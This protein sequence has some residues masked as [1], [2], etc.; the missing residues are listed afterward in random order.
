MQ[1]EYD[2]LLDN[3]TWI[4]VNEPED[5]QVLPG[6]LL[7]LFKV[8]YGANGQV[9]KFKARYVAK[10]YAQ[11]EGVDF[12]DTYAP[13]CKPETFRIL[14][15]TATQK[16]LQ[17]GQMDVKSA[18]LHSNIEEEIYLEQPQ[19]FVKK[20]NSGQKLVCKLNK[21]IY[22][23]KQAAKNW[24]EALT[25]LLLKKGFKRSRNDYCLFV[26]KEDGTFSYVLVWVDDIVVAGATEEAVNEIKSILNETFKMDDRGVLNW[27]LGMQILRSNDK[28]TVDQKKYIETVLQEFNMNECKAV[29]TPGEV[30]LKLVKSNEEKKLV[31]PK[32]YR[33]LVGSLLFI[34]K[35][36]R[37]DILH[38]VNQ[39]SRFLDKPDESHWKA[40]KHVMR[41]LKGTIDL[42]LTFL[43]NSN[44]D[45][46][47]DSDADWSG[48]LNDRKSTTG[49][50]FKFEGSGGAISWEVKKQATVALS[51]VE[52]EYQ[53]MA[54]VVQEA[55]YLRALLEDFGFP[56]KK[57]IDIGE[58]NQS[59]IKMC[60]NP[61]MHKRSKHI[62]TKLHFI[63]ERVENKEVRIH[64]VPTEEMTADILTKSLPR[65]KV[66]RHRTILLG[67]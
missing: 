37:P 15:A 3:N 26:R 27:F 53:A 18:Y 14:L 56:M 63:R 51:T 38:V 57:A 40:A 44:L 25:S 46:I 36:T 61:V 64:Y 10:G 43:K 23:L 62:D 30:N 32:L 6:N 4:L 55:I 7:P 47:G 45:I 1:A 65:V 33:S 31:D 42:R 50:Y 24:Y 13:T 41:Y 66:E 29:A 11:I 59:C 22:G 16:D 28:I 39:L 21:S 12:F 48:D 5:Q 49:Y 17:L 52:A 60:H 54:A 35:Q 8:K 2:S 34:G 19:G 58:D 9:D 20:A 67:H